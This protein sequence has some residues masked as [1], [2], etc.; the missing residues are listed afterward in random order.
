MQAIFQVR[1]MSG[2][3]VLLGIEITN[4]KNFYDGDREAQKLLSEMVGVEDVEFKF[5]AS[6]MAWGCV[7][8]ESALNMVRMFQGL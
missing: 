8:N 5:M 4:P 2:E 1:F 3:S 6:R 7:S